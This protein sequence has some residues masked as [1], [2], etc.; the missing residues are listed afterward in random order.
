MGAKGNSSQNQVYLNRPA[1][2][3]DVYICNRKLTTNYSTLLS[4]VSISMFMVNSSSIPG[5]RL[6]THSFSRSLTSDRV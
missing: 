1:E 3:V 5:D 4:V 6:V 2:S